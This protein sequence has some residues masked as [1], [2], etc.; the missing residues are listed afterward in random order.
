MPHALSLATLALLLL[1]CA[2]GPRAGLQALHNRAV[3]DL[4]CPAQQVYVYHLDGRTK[5]A[6]GC[7]RRLVYVEDC[8]THG[9]RNE[10]TWLMDSPSFAQQ[11]WPQ[12]QW[13]QDQVMHQGMPPAPM[14]VTPAAQSDR[15]R[16]RGRVIPTDLYDD[17]KREPT[18]P[19]GRPPR[20]VRTQL[21]G[22]EA[23]PVPE[24]VLL[25]RQ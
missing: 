6:M 9:R 5:A 23:E 16:A 1:G 3:L 10:C 18:G 24:D 11:S 17:G 4:G 15:N 19:D 8:F 13:A 20:R 14:A 21:F 22:D 2:S 12:N 7:G 25:R